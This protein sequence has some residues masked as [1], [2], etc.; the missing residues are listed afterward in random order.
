MQAILLFEV[1]EK[2]FSKVEIKYGE[3]LFS[4]L[5][6]ELHDESVIMINKTVYWTI[7]VLMQMVNTMIDLK[8]S[9]HNNNLR[10]LSRQSENQI[11][12]TI[13]MQKEFTNLL[14]NNQLPWG[15]NN[16][17][18]IAKKC[19]SKIVPCTKL[20]KYSGKFR[21]WCSGSSCA[22]W[23]YNQDGNYMLYANDTNVYNIWNCLIDKFLLNINTCH[24]K[25]YIKIIEILLNKDYMDIGPLFTI[26]MIPWSLSNHKL[27]DQSFKDKV[28]TIFILSKINSIIS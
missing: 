27:F 20:F 23:S 15:N 10:Y 21:G 22:G 13:I 3:E 18:I 2:N 25:S 6:D 5:L 14:S 16:I 24:N 7:Y 26:S 12:T 17:C 4:G 28:L 9:Y 1:V 8:S 11:S 19:N